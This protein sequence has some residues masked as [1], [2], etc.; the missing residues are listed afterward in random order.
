MFEDS[1]ISSSNSSGRKD[2]YI[3]QAQERQEPECRYYLAESSI[4]K[5]GLGVYTAIDIPEGDMAQPGPDACIFTTSRKKGTEAKTHLWGSKRFGAQWLGGDRPKG[6]CFGFVTNANSMGIK[7]YSV[8]RQ[9]GDPSII[10]T[11]GGLSRYQHPGAGAVTQF[12][13]VFL[14][15]RQNMQAGSELVIRDNHWGGDMYKEEFG[16]PFRTP[17]WLRQYGMCIDHVD[18][19]TATDPS[20]GRGAF[21]RRFLP[22]GTMV[23]PAPLQAFPDRSKFG[24]AGP[25]HQPDALDE[26]LINYSFQP[27]NSGVVLFPYG[28]YFGFVNHNFDPSKINVKLRWSTNFMNHLQWL[29]P[30]ITAEQFWNLYYSG[31]LIVELVATRD[32]EEGEEL[33]MDY[34]RAW[35]NAWNDHVKKWKPYQGKYMYPYQMDFSLPFRTEAEQKDDPYPPNLILACDIGTCLDCEKDVG[36]EFQW[37]EGRYLFEDWEICTI[38]SRGKITDGNGASYEYKVALYPNEHSYRDE[39]QPSGSD[40]NKSDDDE[41]SYVITQVPHRAIRFVDKPFQSDQHLE[42]SFRHPMEFPKEM[43]PPQWR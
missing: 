35:E 29:D 15:A 32:I 20:M 42:G 37:E 3:T 33:F 4:P 1:F 22:R 18:I 30:S 23:A 14:E 16:R 27:A 26:M 11:T 40:D 31:A 34:G 41:P 5:A 9:K 2:S 12:Y 19:Q 28:A 6:A 39:L 7:K 38:L 21:A 17:E 8:A 36:I 10:Y 25:D 13:G 43:T 24:H